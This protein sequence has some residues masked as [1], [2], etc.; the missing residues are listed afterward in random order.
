MN[1]F[2]SSEFSRITFPDGEWVDIKKEL[3]QAEQDN[4]VSQMVKTAQSGDKTAI[5]VNAG[6]LP[7]MVAYVV[8]WS[9]KENGV[10]VLVTPLN[11]SRLA[12]RY[13]DRIIVEIDRVSNQATE[14]LKKN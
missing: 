12:T 1:P 6:K 3:T 9:F 4:I 11:I 7:L 5:E 2:V 10:A 14:W 13:R 8:A